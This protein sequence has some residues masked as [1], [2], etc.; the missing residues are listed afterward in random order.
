MCDIKMKVQEPGVTTSPAIRSCLPYSS[1][2]LAS[3]LPA[4]SRH[5]ARPPAK[6]GDWAYSA[7]PLIGRLLAAQITQLLRVGSLWP[8]RPL[9]QARPYCQRQVDMPWL[10]QRRWN[11][12][13][14]PSSTEPARMMRS[15][16]R[17]VGSN[18]IIIHISHQSKPYLSRYVSRVLHG[19]ERLLIKPGIA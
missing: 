8:A 15:A 13:D 18:C 2:F 3:I 12:S 19:R 16:I 10:Q 7:E 5:C 4:R 1:D 14:K 9:N 11:A 17:S 6:L